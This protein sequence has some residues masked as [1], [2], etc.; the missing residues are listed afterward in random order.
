MGS[1]L[2]STGGCQYHPAEHSAGATG[3]NNNTAAAGPNANTPAAVPDS[4]TDTATPTNTTATKGTKSTSTTSA[5]SSSTAKSSGTK[6]KVSMAGVL[7]TLFALSGLA[8]GLCETKN[9]TD[10]YRITGGQI[11]ITDVVSCPAG[12]KECPLPY[13]TPLKD[14][15]NSGNYT[16]TPGT[17]AVSI[18]NDLNCDP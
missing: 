2:L 18:S 5:S 3:A 8:M 13:G 4:T 17:A 12:G 1:L 15:P 11:A 14:Y 16:I 9:I 7:F 6:S 10:I